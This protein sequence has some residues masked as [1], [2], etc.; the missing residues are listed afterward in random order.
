MEDMRI[1]LDYL[2]GNTDKKENAKV[3][4]LE[5]QKLK[6]EAVIQYMTEK[7]GLVYSEEQL[8]IL[9]HHGGMNILACA[10]SGKTSILTHLLAKRI[11]TGEIKDPSKL[12]CT[13]YSRAG[14]NEMDERIQDLFQLLG[15]GYTIKVKTLH[16]LYLEILKQLNYPTDVID[17]KKRITYIIEACKDAK[18]KLGDEDLQQIDTLLSYQINNLLSD[19]DLTNSYVFTLENM[20]REQYSL[21]RNGFNS[22]KMKSG[23]IDFDDMQLYMY[24]ILIGE[25]SKMVIDYCN[26]MWEDFYIDEAQ[27]ISKIQFEILRR[28]IKKDNNLVF[29]GDD[30]Q[31]IYQWRGAD[32][33]IILDIAGYYDIKRFT[34]TTNYRCYS[35]IVN[36]AAVGIANNSRRYNKT[37]KPFK[38]GGKV[39]ICDTGPG[40]LYDITKYAY[41]HIKDLVEKEGVR[42]SDIAV[43]SR[44]NQHLS[45][46]SNMLYR[47]GIYCTTTVDMRMTKSSMYKDIKNVMH[48][49]TNGYN[50]NITASTLWRMCLYLGSSY[51]M[52]LAKVQNSASLSL[53]DTLGYMF[54]TNNDNT[55]GWDKELKIPT[56]V[57]LQVKQIWDGLRTDTIESLREVYMALDNKNDDE[58]LYGLLSLY[59]VNSSFLYKS[60]D[61]KRT[62]N[63]LV[64]YIIELIKNL[65]VSNA[66]TVLRVTEQYEEGR[67]AVPGDKVS[68]TTM[69][70]AKGREWKHVVLF[71]DDNISFPSFYGI[72]SMREKRVSVSD[73]SAYIDEDRRLHYV[74]MTR[75]KMDL[76]IFAD[77]RNISVYTAEALGILKGSNNVKIIN[78]ADN[79]MVDRDIKEKILEK[80]ESE[81]K[82]E[83]DITDIKDDNVLNSVDLGNTSNSGININDIA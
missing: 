58:K 28:I 4:D 6:D 62:I 80:Y 2:E 36:H 42:P 12:I 11:L 41:K 18:Y 49:G 61:R 47:A 16:A 20:T 79:N 64:E 78:M 27:D 59:L 69:H 23:E 17:N 10:G 46:L 54:E 77:I 24:S 39:R 71:A 63:G 31:S 65:G 51:A 9:K 21:I 74:A 35:E 55:M 43:L 67:M 3:V 15:I 44:N 29:I 32:P 8:N 25:H 45:I 40:S 70:G 13:T 19:V 81:Y 72:R 30:D 50:H 14:A 48:M 82:Y 53:K 38:E 37:M 83:V 26:Y 52:S 57:K 33:S 66:M 75:A 5:H 76:T 7:T 34:L 22:R 73:I 68:M 56:K 1:L 60:D